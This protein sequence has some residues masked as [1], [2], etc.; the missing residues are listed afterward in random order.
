M[1]I[2]NKIGIFLFA[3]ACLCSLPSFSQ[4]RTTNKV[5]Q[6][7]IEQ[8]PNSQLNSKGES[9]FEVP[10]ISAK[11][12]V[13]NRNKEGIID[14]VGIKLFNREILDKH[15]SPIYHFIERYLLEL[16]L[17]PNN[18]EVALKLR[19]EKVKIASEVHRI[20]DYQK[21]I[22]Q[23]I[24]SF[25]SDC[26]ILITCNS[27]HYIVSCITDNR[28]LLKMAFP[29]RNE[30]ITGFTKLEAE[31]SIYLSL[32]AHQVDKAEPLTLSD[33]SIYKDSLYAYNEDYYATEEI[34]STSY[35]RMEKKTLVP[36]FS[37][38]EMPESIFNLFNAGYDW[39]V[40]VEITQNL[41]GGKKQTYTLPLY[42]LV[43]FLHKQNCTLYTGI[44]KMGNETIEGTLL[45]VNAELGYQHLLSFNV[46]RKVFVHPK[47]TEVKIKMYSYIPIHNVWTLF[48]DNKNK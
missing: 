33:V 20:V 29:V 45:A 22:R 43:N 48:G 9:E 5:L 24:A 10:T 19:M 4:V 46:S 40:N 8:L 35:Y 2:K 6:E 11:P 1:E 23:I 21:C 15:P 13:F 37:E 38:N 47:D 7:I 18:E 3:C 30:L 12:I 39:G 41:Y 25:T 42:R 34:I 32:L 44:K 26:S 27:N 31:N 14:H 16:L 36:I 17:L 28:N